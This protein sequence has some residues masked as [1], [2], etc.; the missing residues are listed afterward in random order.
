MRWAY[1]VSSGWVYAV[2]C[3][4]RMGEDEDEGRRRKETRRERAND[5]VQMKKGHTELAGSMISHAR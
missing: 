5:L 4:E 2:R 1:L 3:L